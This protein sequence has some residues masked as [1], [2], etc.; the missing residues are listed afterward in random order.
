MGFLKKIGLEPFVIML[1]LSIALAWVAPEIGIDRDPFSLSDIATWGVAG[2][3]FFYGLRLNRDK[4]KAGL[5]NVR[6]HMLVHIST[7]VV[8]PLIMLAVMHLFGASSAQGSGRYLWIGSFFLATLPSTVSSSVVMV[9]IAGGNIPAAIFNASVSSLMGVFLTP[10]WMSLFLEKVDGA[11]G[12]GE[13]IF[14]LIVQVLVPV[15]LGVALNPKFGA[16]AEAH[17]KALR[18][19]DQTIIL[20]IVYTSFC[21]SFYKKMFSGFPPTVIIELS[22]CMVALFFAVYFIIGFLC[23]LMGFNRQDTITALFCGSKKSLVHGSVMSKVLFDNPAV[24]G[25]IL[26][27][28]MLY[29]AYQLIV[30]SV[31]AKRFAR[32]Q[33]AVGKSSK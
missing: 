28:T 9:S 32:I 7:F 18:N 30:V 17:K 16:F 29:H 4:L 14:K 19:F 31:L 22:I 33:S 12:L 2:I 1:F 26:L 27:P 21:D 5:V 15:C 20:L 6:L 10:V 3:F 13:V 24:I 8:F 23:R 11:N 25:V